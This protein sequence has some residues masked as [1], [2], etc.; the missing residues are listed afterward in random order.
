MQG[1][2]CTSERMVA[3]IVSCPLKYL[4]VGLS[5]YVCP[6][7]LEFDLCLTFAPFIWHSR[8]VSCLSITV[9]V[10]LPASLSVCLPACPSLRL[11]LCVLLPIPLMS[12]SP[13]FSGSAAVGFRP[14]SIRLTHLYSAQ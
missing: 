13:F 14:N 2:R 9:F 1:S 5:I 12:C 8:F 11:L 6:S 7:R 10:C 4:P 3:C